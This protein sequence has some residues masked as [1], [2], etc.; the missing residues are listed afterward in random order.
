MSAK[1]LAILSLIVAASLTVN[2]R[3]EEQAGGGSAAEADIPTAPVE[4]DGTRLFLVRGVSSLTAEERARLIYERLHT[5]ADASVDVESLRIVD[6]DPM[7]AFWQ[8]TCR[9]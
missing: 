6:S 9:S 4:L 5:V 7:T 3:L 8:A 1:C 2:A